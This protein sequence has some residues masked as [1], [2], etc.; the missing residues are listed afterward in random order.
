MTRR[1]LPFVA[2]L[3]AMT[4]ALQACAT[5]PTGPF[6]GQSVQDPKARRT[7]SFRCQAEAIW[8]AHQNAD[9]RNGGARR[10][11]QIDNDPGAE[12]REMRQLC[13][14]MAKANDATAPALMQ[15]CTERLAAISRKYGTA[16]ADHITRQ[17]NIC[18]SL[19]GQA[20]PI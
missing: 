15:Q 9:Y 14:Q 8:P 13:W 17:R 7:L 16:A 3:A 12:V 1:P 18:Q 2:G 19:T 11:S 5:V 20:S 4:V 6:P 10:R